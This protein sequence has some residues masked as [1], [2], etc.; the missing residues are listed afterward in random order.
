MAAP[1]SRLEPK[2][3]E[4]GRTVIADALPLSY[5]RRSARLESNQRPSEYL[6]RKCG[7]GLGLGKKEREASSLYWKCAEALEGSEL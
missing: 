6:G 2:G 1:G 4:S 3:E 7:L 5:A